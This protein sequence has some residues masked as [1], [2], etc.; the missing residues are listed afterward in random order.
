MEQRFERMRAILIVD[1]EE[2]IR[3]G[4]R[5]FFHKK[6]FVAYEAFDF[7][8]AL[9]A[10]KS[11]PI[12]IAVIDIRLKNGKNGI[13]LLR[14]LRRIEPDLIEIII[15]GY[16][17]IDTA[18]TSMKEGA[19]DYILKPIDNKKLLD[20]VSKNLEIRELKNENRFLK[21][22][23]MN[24]S[25]PHT[26]ITANQGLKRMMQKVDKIKDSPVTVLIT[27]ESGTGKE[28]LARYIHFTSN[29][30]QGKFVS[31]NCASL[32]ENLL[33]SELFGHEKGA[34]T[35]A[36]ERQ[37]G[38]FE[39]ADRG[40]LFL[41]E[42]GD[43]S[44]NVQAKLLRVIEESS[45]ER[46]GGIRRIHVDV[47]I[48][49]ATNKELTQLMQA[50]RFRDDLYYRIKVVS[51]NLTPLRDRPEDIPLLIDHFVQK[52]QKKYNKALQGFSPEAIGLLTRYEWPGNVRELENVVN[53]AVLLGERDWVDA[54]DLGKALFFGKRIAGQEVDFD[55]IKSLKKAMRDI[56]QLYEPRIIEHFLRKNRYNKSKTARDL[57]ITR[58]TLDDKIQRYNLQV[59]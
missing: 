45:F 32:S 56:L 21:R 48:I 52:Y 22:E 26:F 18:V 14:E 20:V 51:F 15:T 58:K 30:R 24:R 8:S 33:L 12:D 5:N 9:A 50:G 19:A 41:D 35:D 27:G 49:A 11:H 40:T 6:G 47:R 38:K 28:V 4:L 42:I 34:F 16:G 44:P 57:S 10:V 1:D 7:H 3:H 54:A 25:V 23:L 55:R 2:G 46:V 36:I 39:M 17:S 43:M 59:G 37:I 31:I 29:R 53:Q 13:D